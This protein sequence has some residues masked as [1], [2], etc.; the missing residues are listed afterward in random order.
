MA[1][2]TIPNPPTRE[3]YNALYSKLTPVFMQGLTTSNTGAV[4]LGITPAG[5]YIT[6]PLITSMQ[7]AYCVAFI[8]GG[9]WAIRALSRIDN[10][11]LTNTTI[12]VEFLRIDFGS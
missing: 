10:T 8:T 12:N 4:S 6:T 11:P 2:G 7:D 9:N 5:H 1:T 3:E